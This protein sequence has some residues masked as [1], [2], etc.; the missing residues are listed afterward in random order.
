MLT[1][2]FSRDKNGYTNDPLMDKI[3]QVARSEKWVGQKGIEQWA[4]ESY[5][6]TLRTGMYDDW[7]SIS[8]KT[9]QDLI[10]FKQDF[11]VVNA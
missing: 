2:M 8:F 5:K 10:K 7:T 4:K 11:G 1:I 9:E 3:R 6:A